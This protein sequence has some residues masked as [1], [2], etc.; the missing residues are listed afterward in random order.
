MAENYQLIEGF[1]CYAPELAF[2]NR[3]YSPEY[4]EKMFALEENNFWFQA[5]NRILRGLFE[6]FLGLERP[7]NILEI[8]VGTGYVL[9]E[10]ASIKNFRLCGGELHISG[11]RFARRRLPDVE[12]I[13][14]DATRMPFENE[15][16]A[17][18]AF[19]VLEHVDEDTRIMQSV[20]RS[21]KPGGL[22]FITVPQHKWLWGQQDEGAY[23]KRRYS[24]QEMLKK[25]ENANFKIEFVS[26]FVTVLFPLMVLSRWP[27]LKKHPPDS[28]VDYGSQ[29][30]DYNFDELKISPAVNALSGLFMKIDEFCLKMGWSL[31]FGG[32]LAVV[33]RKI[34]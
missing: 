6:K 19:D 1:K 8:G 31:P 23:H 21:L 2:E 30:V 11:L 22:F 9:K 3:D 15:F 24:R 20:H 4:F 18:G 29:E 17:V 33:A 25:L 32:S 13:Q 28:G 16:D 5:R 12:F 10:L 34:S 26:S 27:V 14:L 7:A